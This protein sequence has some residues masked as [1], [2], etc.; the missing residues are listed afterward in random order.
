MF[1]YSHAKMWPTQAYSL[2]RWIRI[3]D[4][5]YMYTGNHHV[6]LDLPALRWHGPRYLYRNRLYNS[7]E[8]NVALQPI[9]TAVLLYVQLWKG[10]ELSI[11]K[12][13]KDAYECKTIPLSRLRKQMDTA[14]PLLGNRVAVTF[15]RIKDH[16]TLV[17]TDQKDYTVTLDNL[18]TDF[19][20]AVP[21][22]YV[23]TAVKMKVA[24]AVNANEK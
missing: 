4:D 8:N 14:Y 16:L 24:V 22:A 3:A 19:H 23:R 17:L 11:T 5:Q 15:E 10:Y 1:Q 7:S 21:S 18:I 13:F 2:K 20:E 12:S 9:L 6:A